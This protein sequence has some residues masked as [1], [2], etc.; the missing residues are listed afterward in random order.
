MNY[1]HVSLFVWRIQ[2]QNDFTPAFE[3]TAYTAPNLLETVSPGT[4]V[5]QVKAEDKDPEGENS[6]IR[7]SIRSVNPNSGQN[8]FYISPESGAITVSRPVT[9]D[10]ETSR[11]VVR[12]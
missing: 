6:E 11:Y 3:K 8:F 7:Y 12:T 4:Q 5:V 9:T 2:D 1:L 10:K